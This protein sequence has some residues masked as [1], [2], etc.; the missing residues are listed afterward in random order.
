MLVLI[1]YILPIIII[2]FIAYISIPTG[3]TIKEYIKEDN[4]E[5]T[6]FVFIPIIN[7]LILFVIIVVSFY[8]FIININKK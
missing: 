2:G 1:F 4:D 7:L 3:Q 6:I 5:L 8:R